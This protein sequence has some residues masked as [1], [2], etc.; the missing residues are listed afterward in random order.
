MHMEAHMMLK[1][2]Q[3]KGAL[4]ERNRAGK[5]VVIASSAIIR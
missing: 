3:L 2:L 1:P 5:S 4:L